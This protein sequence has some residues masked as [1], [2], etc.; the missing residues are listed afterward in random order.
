MPTVAW[1]N[2]HAFAGGLM[3]AMY[4]DYRIF[5][6]SRGF[7]CLNE[8]E[9]GAPL[10]PAMSSIFREKM[11]APVYRALVLLAQR[12]PGPQALEAGIVDGLGAWPEVL[13]LV[14]K[15][16]L[17]DRPKTGVYGYLR[18]EMYR[19]SLK[20]LETTEEGEA[21]DAKTYEEEAQREE[22]GKKRVAEW[23]AKL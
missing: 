4:H 17:A 12:F 1:L 8:L 14:E 20:Y 5:N 18:R 11:T 19:E 2:G 21:R 22:A 16:K 23:K 6:P 3:T 9:M 13:A 15:L 7:L 10:K